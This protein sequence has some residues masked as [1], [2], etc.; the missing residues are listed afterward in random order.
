MSERTYGS[1]LANLAYVASFIMTA[2]TMFFALRV[3]L[4]A[5]F[6]GVGIY[7][8]LRLAGL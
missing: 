4:A 3:S 6:A 2:A 5:A 7:G 1:D 8:G